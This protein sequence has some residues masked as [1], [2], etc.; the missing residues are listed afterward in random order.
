MIAAL[1]F[2]ASAA[3]LVATFVGY[4]AILQRR[5][6]RHRQSVRRG[7]ITPTVAVVIV[8][9]ER[10]RPIDA[11]VDSLLAQRYPAELIRVV[12]V[13]DGPLGSSE[14]GAP[15]IDDPRIERIANPTRRGRAACLNATIAA[16]TET[17]VV[18]PEARQVLHPDA[19]ASLA[20]N[21]ADPSIGAVVAERVVPLDGIGGFARGL[22]ACWTYERAIRATESAIDSVAGAHGALYALRRKAFSPIPGDTA[23]DDLL[24][25]MNV[26]RSGQRVIYD[27]SAI[28]FDL[29]TGEPARDQLRRIARLGAAMTLVADQ[30]W[31]LDARRDRVVLAFATQVLARPFAPLALTAMLASSLALAPHEPFYAAAFVLQ[32][33]F[34]ASPWLAAH[35]PRLA[36]S[37]PVRAAAALT[38][39]NWFALLGLVEA[40]TRRGRPA[41]PLR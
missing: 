16:C 13:H 29:P 7:L 4:P 39:L 19:L 26:V 1:L 21:F 14:P 28:A 34:C 12:I 5:A 32:A 3:T 18:L 15:W 10:C 20:A 40:L 35:W 9:D 22:E 33:V 24:I 27:P 17:L 36:G 30:P 2:W 41:A 38:A 8:V 25:P 6:R 31:L 11:L 37:R 23:L